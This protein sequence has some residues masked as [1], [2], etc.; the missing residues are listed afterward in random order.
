MAEIL[1][2]EILLKYRLVTVLFVADLSRPAAE[3]PVL[4]GVDG[5][6][7]VCPGALSV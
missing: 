6:A 5:L 2:I 7:G 3:C 1:L 4:Y